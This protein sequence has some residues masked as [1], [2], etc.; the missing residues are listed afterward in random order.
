MSKKPIKIVKRDELSRAAELEA[1]PT[2]IPTEEDSARS[3]TKTVTGWIRE[4][5]ERS[6]AE[7]G[8]ML[9]VFR[10]T[11]RPNEA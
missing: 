4:F 2:I 5:K 7:A 9:A 8:K 3:M 11:G 10:D 6:D 1:A